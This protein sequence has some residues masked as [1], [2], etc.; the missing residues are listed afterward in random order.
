MD[1]A[2][3]VRKPVY[4]ITAMSAARLA[5]PLPAYGARQR[6]EAPAWMAQRI[7][8]LSRLKS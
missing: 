7:Y 8:V 5:V 2:V 1:G 6:G 4:L 3:Q